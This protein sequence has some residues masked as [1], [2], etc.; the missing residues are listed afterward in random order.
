[1]LRVLSLSSEIFPRKNF[2][3]SKEN[4]GGGFGERQNTSNFSKLK[5]VFKENFLTWELNSAVCEA[6][7]LRY[8]KQSKSQTVPS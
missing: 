4:F 5:S 2:H 6:I 7:V 3:L 1:M 8:L